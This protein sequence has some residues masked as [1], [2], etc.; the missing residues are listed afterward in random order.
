MGSTKKSTL[1]FNGT[2]EQE[3]ALRSMINEHKD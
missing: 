1:P 3:Q 2:A